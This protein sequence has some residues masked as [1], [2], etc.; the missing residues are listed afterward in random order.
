VYELPEVKEV[1]A[2]R[3]ELELFA[4]AIA[5]GTRPVVSGED[6]KRAL[7]VAN[8]IMEKISQQS[9]AM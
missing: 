4:S 9:F 1:N 8:V 7:E 5:S 2:L 3:H 6:G